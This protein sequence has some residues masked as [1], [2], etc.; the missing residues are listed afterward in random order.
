MAIPWKVFPFAEDW[1][2]WELKDST[3]IWSL[4]LSCLVLFDAGI[5]VDNVLF[6]DPAQ[7]ITQPQTINCRRFLLV[8]VLLICQCR[9]AGHQCLTFTHCYL[10]FFCTE[11]RHLEMWFIFWNKTQL[12]HGWQTSTINQDTWLFVNLLEF[13]S[14]PVHQM[15]PFFLL[16]PDF[17]SH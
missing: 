11:E 7:P 5:S 1:F 4:C 15:L 16:L 9:A 8:H 12:L 17:N 10:L 3:Q 2:E 14:N 13:T 6:Q